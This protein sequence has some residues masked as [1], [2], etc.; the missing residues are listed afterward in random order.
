MHIAIL[1][2]AAV[3]VVSGIVV[4]RTSTKETPSETIVLGESVPTPPD[5]IPPTQSTL[6]P[7]PTLPAK[8]EPTPD[9]QFV[10]PGA[11]VTAESDS[12]L[13]M[14]SSDDAQT[15]TDWYKDKIKELGMTTKSFVQT[16]TN[17]NVLN[18][19]A[20]AKS[21]EEIKVTITKNSGDWVVSIVVER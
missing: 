2:V 7:S 14:E 12:S 9:K 13:T 16:K 3:L 20:A 15:I 17:D 6:A 10:Y 4:R 11:T 21:D 19:L 5:T 8:Q 1:I 18:A